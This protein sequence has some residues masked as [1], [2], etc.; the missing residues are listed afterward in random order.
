M[1]S[2]LVDVRAQ[3]VSRDYL[4]GESEAG[5]AYAKIRAVYPSQTKTHEQVVNCDRKL[6]QD[7]ALVQVLGKTKRIVSS[8]AL[9]SFRSYKALWTAKIGQGHMIKKKERRW[10][11][12]H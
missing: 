5:I 2:D 10:C 9:S 12:G 7:E 3:Q 11:S 8:Q 1:Y 4:N 6:A